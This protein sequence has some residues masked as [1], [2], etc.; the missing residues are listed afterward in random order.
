MQQSESVPFAEKRVGGALAA[1]PGPRGATRTEVCAA[2]EALPSLRSSLSLGD[3]DTTVGPGL[4]ATGSCDSGREGLGWP[5]DAQRSQPE[6]GHV[7]S[8]GVG[9]QRG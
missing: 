5:G 9:F 2:R 4:E 3:G 6:I 1:T 8:S 7:Q